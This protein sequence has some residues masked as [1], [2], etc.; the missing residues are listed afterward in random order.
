MRDD[1]WRGGMAVLLAVFAAE[2]V[3]LW[4]LGCVGTSIYVVVFGAVP[5]AFGL[6]AGKRL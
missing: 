2:V 5:A 1:L 6:L 4:S 3:W